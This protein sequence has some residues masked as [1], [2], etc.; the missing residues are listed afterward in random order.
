[1]ALGRNESGVCH[2]LRG[3]RCLFPGL[4]DVCKPEPPEQPHG[5]SS[6][7]RRNQ[8]GPPGRAVSS[9]LL[10]GGVPHQRPAAQA[11]LALQRFALSLR[12]P[13]SS[14]DRHE[15]LFLPQKPSSHAIKGLAA[16]SGTEPLRPTALTTL[17]RKA[18]QFSALWIHAAARVRWLHRGVLNRCDD[19]L[20]RGVRFSGKER[21]QAPPCGCVLRAEAALCE[22]RGRS[23]HPVTIA[24]SPQSH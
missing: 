3:W 15:L 22:H 17:R 9:A 8:R 2:G 12:R 20:G 13:L 10:C 18:A 14:S 11:N 1:M 23:D 24:I 19:T 7:R 6:R 16:A 4:T 21:L 5:R